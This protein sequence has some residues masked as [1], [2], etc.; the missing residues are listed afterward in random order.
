MILRIDDLES[1]LLNLG[2]NESTIHFVS[3]G[4]SLSWASVDDY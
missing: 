3:V 1:R 2:F 4:T